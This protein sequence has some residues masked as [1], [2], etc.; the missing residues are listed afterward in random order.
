MSLADPYNLNRFIEAQDSVIESVYAELRTGRKTSH[1]M[2][3]IFPQIRGLGHSPTALRFAIS[4]LAEAQAYLQHPILGPRLR[5]CTEMVNAINGRSI[6][7]IFGFPDH[8]KFR[9]CMTLF[10]NA[11]PQ[12]TVFVEALSKYFAGKPDPLTLSR[13]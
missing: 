11:S 8:L 9:S 3:F 5:T 12:E 13:L 6:E 4:S 1:W 10:S 7:G 2:W